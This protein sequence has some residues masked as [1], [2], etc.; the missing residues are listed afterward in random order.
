[1]PIEKRGGG[2]RGAGRKCIGR[3]KLEMFSVRLSWDDIQE[4]QSVARKLKQKPSDLVREI[5]RN[6]M[7]RKMKNLYM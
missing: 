3:S 5:I 1:M 6:E 2:N 4:L 7:S